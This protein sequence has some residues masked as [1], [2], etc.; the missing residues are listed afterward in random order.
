MKGKSHRFFNSMLYEAYD[1]IS[2]YQIGARKNRP[3]KHIYAK[4]ITSMNQ[5]QQNNYL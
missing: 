2:L 3:K 5:I 4:P 1:F